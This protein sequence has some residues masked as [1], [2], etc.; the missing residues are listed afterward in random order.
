MAALL[1]SCAPPSQH[2]MANWVRDCD[3]AV[4]DLQGGD[5]TIS[6]PLSI[7]P[8][9]GDLHVMQGSLRASPTFPADRYLLEVGNVSHS[10]GG[11]NMDVSLSALFLDAS[12]VAAGC[13]HTDNLQGGVIGPQVYL[14]NFT[15]VG[16]RISK[17]FEVTVMQVWAAEFWFGD[18]RKENGTAT[19][20][21]TGIWK[22]G[23]DGVVSDCVIF[24][25]RVGLWIAGEANQVDAVHT[26]NLASGN[27]GIGILTTVAQSR[28]TNCYLDCERAGLLPPPFF[29]RALP[30]SPHSLS[31]QNE[32]TLCTSFS[33]Q[34]MIL[35]PPIPRTLPLRGA[36]SFAA[37]ASASLRP[38]M[39]W[40][41][42]FTSRAIST[43]ETTV[44]LVATLA[45]KPMA[46]SPPCR[47]CP[48]LARCP[49][50]AFAPSTRASRCPPLR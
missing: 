43:L 14:F 12:Q 50:L 4:L 18:A 27:G 47:T 39:A 9:F 22:E 45:C 38:P 1:A 46:S 40:F 32:R 5:Y 36:F 3:G 24:S 19:G 21:T 33:L 34:G 37:A 35:Y 15:S 8:G 7:L 29:F 23:N 6:A 20:N 42:V 31:P 28:F 41:L 17:G 16:A 2:R 26:W 10:G 49:A 30:S 48:L 25:S 13:I 44:I 11:N